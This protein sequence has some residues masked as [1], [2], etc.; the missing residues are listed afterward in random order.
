[1]RKGV[2]IFGRKIRL[3]YIL[4]A[5]FLALIAIS[6]LFEGPRTL[7]AHSVIICLECIGLI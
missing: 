6:A 7:Y 2:N 4:I 1:M 3:A 5:G